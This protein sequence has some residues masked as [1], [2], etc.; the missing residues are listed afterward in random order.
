MTT[1][2]TVHGTGAGV[3]DVD[4]SEKTLLRVDQ[5]FSKK[6]WARGWWKSWSTKTTYHNRLE[7]VDVSGFEAY[8]LKESEINSAKQKAYQDLIEEQKSKTGSYS[9]IKKKLFPKHTNP[10]DFEQKTNNSLVDASE[11]LQKWWVK[12][13]HFQTG[14]EKIIQPHDGS[15]IDWK[16]FLWDGANSEKSRLQAGKDLYEALAEIETSDSLESYHLIGHSH[17]GSVIM[18]ALRQAELDNFSLKKLKSWSTI[19][20][21]FLSFVRSIN[22]LSSLSP[23]FQIILMII[24]MYSV[25]VITAYINIDR[26]DPNISESGEECYYINSYDVDEKKVLINHLDEVRLNLSNTGLKHYGRIE[27][28]NGA[29]GDLVLLPRQFGIFDPESSSSS[30]PENYGIRL[31]RGIIE[32]SYAFVHKED[33]E[34]FLDAYL[35][36]WDPVDLCTASTRSFFKLA[37]EIDNPSLIRSCADDYTYEESVEENIGKFWSENAVIPDSHFEFQMRHTDGHK[38]IGESYFDED[39]PVLNTKILVDPQSLSK[40][41]ES[42]FYF[43]IA[44]IPLVIYLFGI[45]SV[46]YYRKTS[47]QKRN[48]SNFVQKIQKTYFGKWNNFFH[49]EDEAINAISHSTA[50]PIDLAPKKMMTGWMKAILAIVVF[51]IL[52]GLISV[53]F[54]YLLP[55]NLN[56]ETSANYLKFGLEGTANPIEGLRTWSDPKA[57]IFQLGGLWGLFALIG[58]L[59]I[60]IGGVLERLI[61]TPIS[62]RGFN[63]NFKKSLLNAAFGNDLRGFNVESCSANPNECTVPLTRSQKKKKSR[64]ETQAVWKHIPYE[65]ENALTSFVDK[66]LEGV[67]SKLRQQFG[68]NM[69]G[70][71]INNFKA[72][73]ETLTWNELIHT[74]YFDIKEIQEMIAVGLIQSG[75]FSKTPAFINFEK[76]E[77]WISEI[78]PTGAV[79]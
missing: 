60:V 70:A 58:C 53:D 72:F 15:E 33:I 21:P 71:P 43:G 55:A 25:A 24:I 30:I 29:E 5:R 13:S 64:V 28:V 27:S 48:S 63:R 52:S 67:L 3:L 44:L 54:S 74:S 69:G 73:F 22:P 1:I 7:S 65:P 49:P 77:N 8:S 47:Y 32:D 46:R 50:V 45:W 79:Q 20:T 56:A 76:A 41:R 78:R 36:N 19:G 6:G 4:E 62:R 57:A 40:L 37:N 35:F 16:Q 59:I 9:K 2:I 12:G 10:H 34:R 11:G 68:V 42:L 38:I 17:G 23:L 18:E 26:C 66:Y 61:L 39:F 14:I 75:D 31:K 51:S